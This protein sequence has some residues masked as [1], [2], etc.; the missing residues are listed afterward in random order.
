MEMVIFVGTRHLMA[1][2]GFTEILGEFDTDPDF[3]DPPRAHPY[4]CFGDYSPLCHLA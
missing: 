1:F 2:E 4:F 3:V